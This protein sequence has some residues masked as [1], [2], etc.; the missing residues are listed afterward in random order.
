VELR[1]YYDVLRK[2]IWV[3]LLLVAVAVTGVAF[4]LSMSPDLYQADVA[5]MI[6]PR[7]IAPTEAF[8]D[9]EFGVFTSGYRQTV[10]GNMALLIR[11][12]AVLGRVQ[13]R[14]GNISLYQ[15]RSGVSVESIRGTDFMVIKASDPDAARAAAIA[16]VTAEEFTKYFAEVNAAGVRAE[17]TF[18]AGQLDGAR[19]R[20]D[21]AEQAVLG[22]KE[23]TGLVAPREHVT[24]M[25]QRLL[26]I[27]TA[28]ETAKMEEQISRT[29]VN[30]IRSRIGAQPEMRR[31]SVSIGT[32]PTFARLRDTL[33][34]LELEL[35]SLRQ[36][37]TDQHPRVKT[38]VGR[39]AD[40]RKQMAEVA[41]KSINGETM[42]VNPIRENLI[43][44]M[45]DGEV[46][47]AA[48]QARAAG[49]AVIARGMEAR[50]N[51]FPKDEAALARLD[52]DVRLT[53][54][55][56]L[57]L[58]ALHQEALIRENKAA[59]TG[60]AAVLVVDPAAAPVK[61]VS[62]QLPVRA[63]MA[64]LLGLVLGSSLALLMESLDNRIRTSGEAEASYGLPVL[65]SIPT[66]NS[67]THRQLTT[68]PATSAL[69]LSL[70][71]VFL[72]GG[73]IVG[74]Y[75][76]QGGAAEGAARIGQAILQTL[77]GTQ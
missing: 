32:N 25:V 54:S 15:L 14:I 64:G 31:G 3:I 43:R 2:R 46:D 51:K 72:I 10:I 74:F 58:S 1:H 44:G 59:A 66:M 28:N 11:S 18:I 41:E 27:Q 29:R 48:A 55:L 52:R 60:Q 57:R 61:P 4:Q 50:V 19:Q 22:F 5:M 38:A 47:A 13:R 69:L 34:G 37:Y 16:N 39:I 35:A 33:T 73:L 45:I 6:T 49:T 30:F 53:E 77:Q 70:I 17:R 12:D 75:V 71:T 7:I 8:A 21:A 68:A 56:F 76:L 26:D 9:P 63:G 42:A 62:K 67:R 20:L 23:R 65:A 24:W 36:V 40:T